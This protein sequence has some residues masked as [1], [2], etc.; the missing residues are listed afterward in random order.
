MKEFKTVREYIEKYLP[1]CTR[2]HY[3]NEDTILRLPYPYSVPCPDH[4][5]ELYYWDTY[6]LNFGLMETGHFDLAL[7][8][9]NNFI[10]LIEYYG[11]I[12]NANRSYYLGRSQP[13]FFSLIVS[14]IYKRTKDTQWLCRATKALILE[15]EFWQRYRMTKCGLNCY[16]GALPREDID[17]FFACHK[18][19]TLLDF[20]E[21]CKEDIAKTSLALAESGWDCTPRF[22]HE[23]GN[24]APVDLNSLLY[25]LESNIARFSDILGDETNKAKFELLAAERK[26]RMNELLWNEENGVFADYNFVKGHFSPVLSAA[27]F[28][29][30]FLG[31]AD[32]TQARAT[33]GAL[34]RL[35]YKCGVVACEKHDIKGRYQWDYPNAWAPVQFAVVNGLLNYGYESEA[36]RIAEKYINTVESTFEKTGRLWEKYNALDGSDNVTSEKKEKMPVMLGWTSGVYVY[37]KEY[38]VK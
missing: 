9:A 10:Y 5:Q 31:V 2:E 15:H 3:E 18:R 13:P 32:E 29:P 20:P 22:E 7:N 1:E 19:R 4:F 28:F 11:Y 27:S 35:E 26:S 38:I 36:K 30:L 12:P 16:G 25:A 23:A 37:F 14:E 33:V 8:N 24:Y 17:K 34:E 6:F 21:E